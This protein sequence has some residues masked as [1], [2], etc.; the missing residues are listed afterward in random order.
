MNGRADGLQ[1]EYLVVAGIRQAPRHRE[2]LQRLPEAPRKHAGHAEEQLDGHLA[3]QIAQPGGQLRTLHEQ[4]V[5]SFLVDSDT[6][7]EVEQPPAGC[8]RQ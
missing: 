5:G 4:V 2:D 7:A 6:P 1:L 3:L 8:E